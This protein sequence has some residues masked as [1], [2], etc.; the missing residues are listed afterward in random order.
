M[1]VKNHPESAGHRFARKRHRRVTQTRPDQ[2]F[3]LIP[4]VPRSWPCSENTD[5]CLCLHPRSVLAQSICR[6]RYSAEKS[7]SRNNV[8]SPDRVLSCQPLKRGRMS[9]QAAPGPSA[10]QSFQRRECALRDYNLT[11]SLRCCAI[12]DEG[13]LTAAQSTAAS[14]KYNTTLGLSLRHKS[15]REFRHLSARRQYEAV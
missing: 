13:F 5:S 12:R 1:R 11:L 15:L 14:W 3:T 2:E 6:K 9:L 8:S 7:T 4:R 10:D